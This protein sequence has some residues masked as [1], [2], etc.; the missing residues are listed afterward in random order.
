MG[1][2]ADQDPWTRVRTRHGFQADEVISGLQKE[3]RRA[4]TENAVLLAYEML[5][6]SP[7]LE[8][9]LWQ[10]LKIISVEDIGWGELQAPRLILALD[11]M[12]AE[13]D[14]QSVERT[15]LAVH[16]VRVLAS[17]PK[18]RSSDEMAAWIRHQVEQGELRPHIPDY[19]LDVHTAR[20]Q[21]MGRGRRHFL[22]EAA[23]IAPERPG[24]DRTYR[25]RLLQ[26]LED[27][28]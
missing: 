12:R 16:A 5:T 25:E 21:Q 1:V 6:T 23:Q 24:R 7:E 11:R 22:E 9:K 3:I 10:R 4:N 27:E 26:A 18:D 19:A 20:G 17:L 28:G 2:H 14:Y 15:L 8:A 13:F